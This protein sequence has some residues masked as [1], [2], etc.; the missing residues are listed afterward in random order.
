VTKPILVT[1]GTGT[2]GREVVRRLTA[3]G[4]PVRVLSRRPRPEGDRE[5]YEWAT[6]DLNT[7][8]GLAGAVDGVGTVV[9]CATAQGRQKDVDATRLLVDAA[10]RAELPHLVY[11]S[12]VGI[13][14]IPFSYYQAKVDTERVIQDSGLPWT[15][16]RATQFHDLVTAV[17]SAQRWL[18]VTLMPAG[19]RFQPVDAGDVADRLVELAL[20]GPSGQV[21]DLG[22]PEVL[23][24]R[25]LAKAYLKAVGRRRAVVQVPLP[26][27][28]ARAVRAGANLTPE[29]ADGKITY[30]EF[31]ARRFGG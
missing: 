26:G 8:A 15:I 7:G 24:V 5:P 28:A 10:K 2:L 30:A 13:E 31:L 14:K 23:T 27:A 6:A 9:H 1:G 17:S 12:I 18:P 3:A 11:I 16:L 29:H 4:Q 21:P 19:F 25:D 22:G 20:A